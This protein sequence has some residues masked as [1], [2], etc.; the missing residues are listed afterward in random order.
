MIRSYRGEIRYA[1]EAI[2]TTGRELFHATV[3]PDGTRTLRCLCE[4][5]GIGLTRDVTYTVNERFEAMDCFVRITGR[6]GLIGTGWFCFSDTQAQGEIVTAIEGRITQ[7]IDTPGRVKL[8]GTHP[9]CL[10]IWKCVHTPMERPGEVQPLANCFSSSLAAGTGASGPMLVHK[11]YDMR[12][13]G[14]ETVTVPAGTFDCQHFSWDT[15]TGRVLQM[16]TVPGDWLPVQVRVP[17]V[18]RHY[19]LIAFEELPIR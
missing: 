3:Y 13:H 2:G 1:D 19:Q 8:F 9:L 5:D 12:Y 11:H 10:D 17:E 6:E 14:A 16:Y 18:G 15:H 4:M 7:R